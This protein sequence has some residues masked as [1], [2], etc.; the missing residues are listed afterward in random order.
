MIHA[1]HLGIFTYN[2]RKYGHPIFSGK[3]YLFLQYILQ[4]RCEEIRIH[5][6]GRG[7]V[8]IVMGHY[9]KQGHTVS[10]AL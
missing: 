10:H 9:S 6:T 8:L 3:A 2:G 5:K 1:E 7:I 4:N